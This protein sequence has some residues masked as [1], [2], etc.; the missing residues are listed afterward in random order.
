M[1]GKQSP[2]GKQGRRQ[3]RRSASPD[4]AKCD[5]SLRTPV[6]PFPHPGAV[7]L[8]FCGRLRLGGDGLAV[9]DRFHQ[10]IPHILQFQGEKGDVLGEQ[11]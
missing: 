8:L 6:G 9:Q 11:V 10:G 5:F 1:T 2:P 7:R 3:V 4:K